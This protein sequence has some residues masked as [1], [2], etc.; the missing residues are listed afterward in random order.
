MWKSV[1]DHNQRM[2]INGVIKYLRGD[3]KTDEEIVSAIVKR[4]EN[5]TPEYV[6]NLLQPK[7]G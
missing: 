3:G 1:E 7:A 6:Q 5:V 2:E 4:F